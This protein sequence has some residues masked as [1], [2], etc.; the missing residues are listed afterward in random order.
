MIM[1]KIIRKDYQKRLS[2]KIIRKDYQKYKI[3]L[4]IFKM[5]IK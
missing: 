2:E 5:L 1:E 4:T 3:I